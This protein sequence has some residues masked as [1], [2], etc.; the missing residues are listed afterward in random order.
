MKSMK[1]SCTCRNK[2]AYGADNGPIKRGLKAV[3]AHRGRR[4]SDTALELGGECL[5]E[6]AEGPGGGGSGSRGLS[7]GLCSSNLALKVHPA[8][9]LTCDHET[10]W[11]SDSELVQM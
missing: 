1:P 4:G 5:G 7:P 9:K 8:L 10:E 11:N 6:G 2:A 3:S